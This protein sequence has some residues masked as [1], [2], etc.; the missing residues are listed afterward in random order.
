MGK[1]KKKTV[2]YYLDEEREYCYD[3]PY[4]EPGARLITHEQL[5][6]EQK[7]KTVILIEGGEHDKDKK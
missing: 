7:T 3:K 6:Q 5:V 2:I 4:R 1:K